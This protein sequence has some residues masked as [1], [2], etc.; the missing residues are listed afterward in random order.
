MPNYTAEK[1]SRKLN[2]LKSLAGSTWGQNKETMV[3]T[4]KPICRSVLEYAA[5][6]WA[7]AISPPRWSDLQTDP[8]ETHSKVITKQYLATTHLPEHPGNKHLPPPSL[9]DELLNE[10]NN[11]VRPS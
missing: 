10:Y 2:I 1:A 4:Y 7:P 11:D 8:L 6:I 5:P 9:P 3:M